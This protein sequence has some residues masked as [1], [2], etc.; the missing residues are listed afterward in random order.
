MPQV[1]FAAK[2][3][4]AEL[5]L[6]LAL[7]HELMSEWRT[8]D[9]D[10]FAARMPRGSVHES[11]STYLKSARWPNI[12]R[13]QAQRACRFDV[14]LRLASGQIDTMH[15]TD[16]FFSRGDN[17]KWFKAVDMPGGRGISL[18]R[19]VALTPQALDA[20]WGATDDERQ[21]ALDEARRLLESDIESK[22]IIVQLLPYQDPASMACL[23][24]SPPSPSPAHAQLTRPPR[25]AALAGR[26][27]YLETLV[28]EL[29]EQPFQPM[30]RKQPHK[31]PVTGWEA[32]LKAYFWPAPC[33]GYRQSA[34]GMQPIA[35][36]SRQ[37]AR[38]LT[39]RG[40]WNE[41]EQ[42][43]A[44]ALAYAI[45]A[46]GGVPQDPR[47]VTAESVRRVFQAALDNDDDANAHM[48]SGWTKVAA[49]AT[50]HLEG[51]GAALPQTIWD[52][53]VAAAITSRLD[54]LL[55][56]GVAPSHV[57]PGVG[58]VP[59]RGG[60]RPR[61]LSRPWPSGYR[62]W[63]GQ[64]AGSQLVREI[65]DILN[66]GGYPKMPLP[67]GGSGDWTTR[68]VEMVLFMDGY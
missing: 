33:E 55:P 60:T 9:S 13:E 40:S 3:S 62:S 15:S 16:A 19:G 22:G 24:S 31:T 12:T 32:R 57:F 30:Y 44:V 26:T 36:E 67:E 20:W 10:P 42:R 25:L 61:T 45:F 27:Q 35:E 50:A 34:R 6:V 14:V 38:A 54:D 68:G 58:T 1:Q 56:E 64:V 2:K 59:G 52:S 41:A 5:T 37:L 51:A 7:W 21:Q 8:P 18:I 65:R 29:D 17:G 49:F 47:T 39:V 28:K 53:R 46:W 48:N 43:Q 63:A 11:L 66:R 4:H 23:P